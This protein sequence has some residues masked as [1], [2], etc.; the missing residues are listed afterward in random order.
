MNGKGQHE[1]CAAGDGVRRVRWAPI[2]IVELALLVIGLICAAIF[3]TARLDGYFASRAAIQQFEN[4]MR[5]ENIT[6]AVE[7][8]TRNL[9][10]PDFS[11]WSEGRVRAYT[12]AVQQGGIALAVLEIPRIQLTV[13]VFD[14]TDELTLNRGAGLIAGTAWPGEPGNVGIAGHRDGF[15]RKLKDIRPGDEIEL[16]RRTGTDVYTADKIQIVTPRDISVLQSDEEPSLTLVTCYPFY[17]I[18][19]APKRFVVKAHLKRHNPA[20]TAA[21]ASRLNPQPVNPALEEQ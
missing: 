19:G 20:G 6:Q 13:P 7:D 21:T 15:F 10:Q 3:A 4:S 2:R 12:G 8:Q 18:G 9:A 1:K 14:G 17:S 5:M 11:D 16:H